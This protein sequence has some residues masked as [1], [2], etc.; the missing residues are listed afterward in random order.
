MLKLA[1]EIGVKRALEEA[2]I[3]PVTGADA[4]AAAA[5]AALGAKNTEDL[6]EAPD[7]TGDDYESGDNSQVAWG[8]EMSL[9]GGGA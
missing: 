6:G 5:V 8:P 7:D 9:I 3:A 2:G 4:F 1:Y